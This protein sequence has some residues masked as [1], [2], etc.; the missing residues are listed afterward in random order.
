VLLESQWLGLPVVTTVA[1][2]AAEALKDGV[3]GRV[4]QQAE[5]VVIADAVVKILK[6]R[7]FLEVSRKEGP[8]FIAAN[9]GMERMIRETLA[10]Y[11]LGRVAVYQTLKASL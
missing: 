4:I 11:D 3:T 1:G 6:D 5:A 9:Y 8:A 2:G 7:K 10:V